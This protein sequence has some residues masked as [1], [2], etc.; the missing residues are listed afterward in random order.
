MSGATGG[1]PGQAAAGKNGPGVRM[2]CPACNALYAPSVL[3]CEACGTGLLEIPDA[4]LLSGRTLDERYDVD[5]VVGTGGMGTVYRARQRGMERE[6]AIKV[7]HPHYAVEPRAVKRFFREAQA[8]S[9]LIHP[10]I[11]TV[12]DFGRSL[13]GHLYMVMEILEGWTLGDLIHYRAP[14]APALA[15]AI[16][17]QVC[18]ALEEAHKQ[19]IVHRDLKPDNILLTQADDGLWA[20]VLDFGI[21]R[22]MKD[23]AGGL[24]RHHST[25]EIAGTPAYMSPE[26]ILGKDPDTRSDLYSLGIIL[27]EMLTR[28]RPFDDESSVALCMRQLN[29]K[30]PRVGVVQPVSESLERVVAGLLEKQPADRLQRA[31]E[32]KAALMALPE[33]SLP[34]ATPPLTVPGQGGG[35]IVGD[36]TTRSEHPPMAMVESTS[37]MGAVAGFGGGSA[38]LAEVIERFK[39]ETLSFPERAGQ[40]PG[41]KGARAP[42]GG[43]RPDGGRPAP[44]AL[45]EAPKKARPV[46]AV[47]VILAEHPGAL[48]TGEIGAWIEAKAQER[49]AF[50]VVREE[51][52]VT[53]EVLGGADQMRP[54]I[55][56]LGALQDRALAQNVAL[57]I[58]FA[59][60]AP[61]PGDKPEANAVAV[62][63]DLARRLAVATTHG[64]VAVSGALAKRAGL[65]IRPQTTV[66]M[67]DGSPLECSVVRRAPGRPKSAPGA[68]GT[69][70]AGVGG[71]G[72]GGSVGATVAAGG[73]DIEL[74]SGLLW[75]RGL[76]LRRLGQIRGSRRRGRDARRAADGAGGR[77]ARHGQVG[78]PGGL[79]GRSQQRGRARVAGGG[80]P[81]GPHRGAPPWP[82]P[83]GCRA[84]AGGRPISI[85][86]STSTRRPRAR[87][88]RPGAA[89]RPAVEPPTPRALARLIVDALALRA[90]DGALVVAIDD[91]HLIDCACKELLSLV[92][93]LA[94]GKP[95]CFVATARW[96]KPDLPRG[97]AAAGGSAAARPA[98]HEPDGRGA[99]RAAAPAPCAAGRGAG[100][101]R[102][103]SGC[104]PRSARARTRLI[105]SA[106]QAVDGPVPWLLATLLRAA[107]AAT[108]ERAWLG[109]VLGEGPLVEEPTTQA[110]RLY[111]EQ[112]LPRELA[113]WL[114]ERLPRE[115]QIA[116]ELAHAFREPSVPD[117][118]RRAQRTERLGLYRLAALEV[119]TALT[120]VP[121]GERAARELEI[122]NLRARAGDVKGAVASFDASSRAVERGGGERRPTAL[123][124][125]ARTLLDLGEQDR[126][127]EALLGGR[128]HRARPEG[129]R[130]AAPGGGRVAHPARAR[131]PCCAAIPRAPR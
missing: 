38:P 127:D 118:A 53:L 109:A 22:I 113:A 123:L 97:R 15:I 119:E 11:V 122:A 90:K 93:E 114:C 50:K 120:L 37:M 126:A 106:T 65:E 111:L 18:D 85:R 94:K 124:R 52:R 13:E 70:A 115:G 72:G 8:A 35:R 62:A 80:E 129:G 49:D 104:R 66:F 46:A 61:E 32:V 91:V 54:A 60:V 82:R 7:L 30:A 28:Q 64:Q 101:T 102:W 71:V 41:D 14:L 20:K 36:H 9:R 43:R 6:V 27:Y 125:F 47:A 42:L 121:P 73:E 69:G 25:V 56:L 16:A 131:G 67:P 23:D 110:A 103:R 24:D 48:V 3:V 68:G 45:A 87:A 112:S 108:A 84:C 57:R 2:I 130:R 39:R 88:A 77:R 1:V 75:G 76:Q 128:A 78:A 55:D 95:W 89:R 117:A 44:L 99:A 86:W 17:T 51:R 33:A 63:L 81:A 74:G 12:Y 5:G 59:A 79:P 26:Q 40:P 29:E 92:L 21:A 116:A 107:D 98:R 10:N 96:V 31:R 83:S 58:G 34:F 105:P 100:G 4:P 19:R